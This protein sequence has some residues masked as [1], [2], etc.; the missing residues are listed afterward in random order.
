MGFSISLHSSERR[1]L[2]Y[3]RMPGLFSSS[4]SP[5]GLLLI[6]WCMSCAIA[7]ARL[8]LPPAAPLVLCIYSSAAPAP[9]VR[10]C[11]CGSPF[12]ICACQR[13]FRS[14]VCIPFQDSPRY[15]DLP[16]A[17]T[18]S[19]ASVQLFCDCGLSFVRAKYKLTADQLIC[20]AFAPRYALW[21]PAAIPNRKKVAI[22]GVFL[23]LGSLDRL[24]RR[25]GM[26]LGPAREQGGP[27][28]A[29]GDFGRALGWSARVQRWA[30]LG[31]G[32]LAGVVEWHRA[33]ATNEGLGFMPGA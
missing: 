31:T 3:W 33:C 12:A 14:F 19:P 22:R 27:G 23:F 16:V 30:A 9:N 13:D 25:S 7:A 5:E 29:A 2:I 15:G 28:G 6:C 11:W 4:Y 1:S 26:N 18:N 17:K 32:P 20:C 21:L 8:W 24:E 10:R